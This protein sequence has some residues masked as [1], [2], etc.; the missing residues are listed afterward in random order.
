M[1]RF[2]TPITTKLPSNGKIRTNSP[3]ICHMKPSY[4]NLVCSNR[5]QTMKQNSLLVYINE[6]EK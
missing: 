1:S 4:G 5:F 2:H 6:Q 3:T